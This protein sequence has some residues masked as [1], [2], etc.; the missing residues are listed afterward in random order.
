[1]QR[2]KIE[3]VDLANEIK[4]MAS[5]VSARW[6]NVGHVEA[7]FRDLCLVAQKTA[8]DGLPDLALTSALH[9]KLA[10]QL[11][12]RE[13]V[14]REVDKSG[15]LLR[16]Y[17]QPYLLLDNVRA[18]LHDYESAKRES[19][20]DA[21]CAAYKGFPKLVAK[22]PGMKK[23]Q[24]AGL[25]AMLEHCRADNEIWDKALED[26]YP[27]SHSFASGLPRSGVDFAR[28][29]SLVSVVQ[30][31]DHH[32]EP[33]VDL[34]VS[35]AYNHLARLVTNNNACEVIAD[36]ARLEPSCA[37]VE[38]VFEVSFE[39][40][41]PITQALLELAKAEWR[42]LGED[43]PEQEYLAAVEDHKTR[44]PLSEE[45]KRANK[46][47]AFEMVKSLWNANTKPSK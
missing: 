32:N 4:Q 34:L 5:F 14:L 17:D 21:D 45:E 36:L 31:V 8:A 20:Y 29:I 33:A 35:S 37:R 2:E 13:T 3:L 9:E 41:H 12:G 18:R 23:A 40:A 38:P 43:N 39:P 1:M 42:G 22:Y 30:M 46:A 19:R 27:D 16:F 47:K 26:E 25:L 11:A 44:K 7:L 10:E 24:P 6:E 28:D 15:G